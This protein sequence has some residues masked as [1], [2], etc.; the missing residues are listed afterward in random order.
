M[1]LRLLLCLSLLMPT[2]AGAEHAC[3]DGYPM[4]TPIKLAKPLPNVW[5]RIGSRDVRKKATHAALKQ[6]HVGVY[7]SGYEEG[8]VGSL[9]LKL[10]D[11]YV[12]VTTS[13]FGL[14]VQY[15]ELMPKCAKCSSNTGTEEQFISGTRLRLG[16]TKAE[17]SE[18]LKS[19]IVADL[20]DITHEETKA[21]GGTRVLH[22]EMLSL[23]FKNNRLVR[24]SVYVYE[25]GA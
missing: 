4:G 11:G 20:T 2:L 19:K 14:G 3:D 7:R 5:F 18:L 9:C 24:F 6:E 15:S 22:T 16:M 12:E 25:E 1:R 13:D 10:N 21:V 17:T 8:P 23:E